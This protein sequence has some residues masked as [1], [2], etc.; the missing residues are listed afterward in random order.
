MEY[1][2]IYHSVC[3]FNQLL[4]DTVLICMQSILC[5]LIK[6]NKTKQK[7]NVHQKYCLMQSVMGNALLE[8]K[9]KS[10]PLQH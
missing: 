6:L 3:I 10:R 5:S 4:L 2:H 7:L 8:L 9:K 1:I